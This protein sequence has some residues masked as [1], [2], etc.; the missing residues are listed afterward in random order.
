MDDTDR[1][2][3]HTIVGAP[4]TLVRGSRKAPPAP[5][6]SGVAVSGSNGSR[7]LSDDWRH[8]VLL[9]RPGDPWLAGTPRQWPGPARRWIERHALWIGISGW[10]AVALLATAWL[11]SRLA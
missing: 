9:R 8:D 11:F 2:F 4:V 5:L 6:F 10:V 7:R 3:T 1:Y